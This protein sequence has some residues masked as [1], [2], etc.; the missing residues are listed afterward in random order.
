MK[1]FYG[2]SA[3]IWILSMGS[4]LLALTGCTTS[5]S[6]EGLSENQFPA[7]VKEVVFEDGINLHRQQGIMWGNWTVSF[8]SSSP[9][10]ERK[11]DQYFGNLKIEI[12]NLRCSNPASGTA[13]CMMVLNFENH[14]CF[15]GDFGENR[16]LPGFVNLTIK[17]PTALRFE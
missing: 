4:M 15:V 5:P 13:N 7:R 2:R 6:W 12:P 3:R 11:R 14:G 9:I 1:K 8:G 17:C 16:K 10:A